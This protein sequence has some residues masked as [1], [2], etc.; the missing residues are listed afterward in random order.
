MK[1]IRV[2][3]D[4]VSLGYFKKWSDGGRP[5]LTDNVLESRPFETKELAERTGKWAVKLGA[6]YKT[7]SKLTKY[8]VINK[9]H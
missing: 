8:E 9:I 1:I 7:L 3:T 4:R 6:F 5:V 2:Y